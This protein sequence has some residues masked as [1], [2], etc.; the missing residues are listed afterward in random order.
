MA[1]I[2][3]IDL[4]YLNRAS[5]TNKA[6]FISIEEDKQTVYTYDEVYHSV[7]YKTEQLKEI[8]FGSLMMLLYDDTV[9]FITSFLA[10]QHLGLICVPMVY[11]KKR[12]HTDYLNEVLRSSD[13]HYVLTSSKDLEKIKVK[14][15]NEQ[16]VIMSLDLD[17]SGNYEM[18]QVKINQ[19]S[20]IQ[21]TSGSTSNPKGVVVSQEN[22][23]SNQQMIQN[24]FGC[25]ENS[26]IFS[27]LPFYHDMGLIG[28]ILH[29]LYVGATCILMS[30]LEVIQNPYHW[31]KA[32]SDLGV[33]H[34]GGPNFIYD[35]CSH[36]ITDLQT[37]QLDLSRWKVAYNGS[38]PIQ[39]A[40][41]SNFLNKFQSSGF[42]HEAFY[43]CYGLAEA[44]LLVAGGIFQKREDD[45]VSSGKICEG[46]EVVIVDSDNK[47]VKGIPGEIALWGKSISAGYW[48]SKNNDSFVDL[49]GK[50]YL[51]TGDLGFIEDNELIITGRLKELIIVN[52]KNYHPYDIENEIAQSVMEV[53]TNG[54]IVSYISEDNREIPLVFCEIQRDVLSVMNPKYVIGKIDK[55]ILDLLG[56]EAYDILLLIPRK[57]S[58]TSSGKLQRLK[59]KTE[60]SEDTI[61]F[62]YSKKS[63]NH[64]VDLQET[65]DW[66]KEIVEEEKLDRV[67][68]FLIEL[69][70]SKLKLNL[71]LENDDHNLID[72]GIDSLKSVDLINAINQT[73]S[74]NIQ[75]T[76][77][78]NL[79][80][81]SE[82][83]EMI[84]NLLWLKS[85]INNDE[86]IV[87]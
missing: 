61:S 9:D 47:R 46:V 54:V 34:S 66:A 72:L 1:F 81:L 74:I 48:K 41:I 2:H 36:K 68:E 67:K 42:K 16:V 11:P 65:A 69:L 40:T 32:V 83:E 33:T 64:S 60:Y 85:T 58:R 84:K 14:F 50:K 77:L 24:L 10:C 71:P 4:F 12:K 31:L 21:Y 18:S 8:P 22:L 76:A 3:Y 43:T 57:L 30:P 44:T 7:L 75:V 19:V 78:L 87:L 5:F 51:K 6:S 53:E 23:L 39:N 59:T 63:L 73:L 82:L 56:I 52:G 45:F 37:E 49:D 20:F 79:K 35:L 86:Q 26:I 38:E 13:C 80:T 62:V 28:N 17:F 25:D 15:D 29:S 70:N 27:W 55:I